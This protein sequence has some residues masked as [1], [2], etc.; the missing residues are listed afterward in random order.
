MDVTQ[1]D[2]MHEIPSPGTSTNYETHIYDARERSTTAR[3]TLQLRWP[4]GLYGWGGLV[5]RYY[6]YIVGGFGK[7]QIADIIRMRVE[8]GFQQSPPTTLTYHR[9]PYVEVECTHPEGLS[10][11]H[12]AMSTMVDEEFVELIMNSKP[13][14]CVLA[15]LRAEFQDSDLVEITG[16]TSEHIAPITVTGAAKQLGTPK[17]NKPSWKPATNFADA[18]LEENKNASSGA[19]KSNAKPAEAIT[20]VEDLPHAGVSFGSSGVLGF[21][22]PRAG[23]VQGLAAR[24]MAPAIVLADSMASAIVVPGSESMGGNSYIGMGFVGF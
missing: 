11:T 19:P 20:P 7:P 22:I 18:F 4:F 14:T 21:K 23:H 17:I 10:S 13:T 5:N 3:T 12:A 24:T 6:A 15:H 8:D 2:P 9:E 1:F 16:E